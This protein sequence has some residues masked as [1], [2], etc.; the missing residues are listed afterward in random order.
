MEL[1][2]FL[3]ICF[4]IASPCFFIVVFIGYK[5]L[6]KVYKELEKH[7]ETEITSQETLET[8]CKTYKLMAVGTMGT[9][10]FTLLYIYI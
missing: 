4:K 2:E 3:R 9:G 7:D 6:R 5:E 1:R 10:I 8:I